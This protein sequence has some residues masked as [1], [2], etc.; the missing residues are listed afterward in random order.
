MLSTIEKVIILKTVSIFAS[1]SDDILAE[2]AAL[3]EEVE[4]AAGATLFAKGD[5]GNSMYIVVSGNLRVHDGENTLNF[6]AEREVVGE[7]AL[8]DPEPRSASV[9]AVEDTLLFRIDQE[10]FYDLMADR[11]EVVRGIMRV[12]TGSLRARVRDVADLRVRIQ[13]LEARQSL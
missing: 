2:T 6:R 7:M 13:A 12:I 9:T 11:I 1:T 8:L 5:L 10:P 4:L 3:V